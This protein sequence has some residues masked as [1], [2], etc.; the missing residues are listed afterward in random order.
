MN[1]AMKEV[2]ALCGLLEATAQ[3]D[4]FSGERVAEM[5]NQILSGHSAASVASKHWIEPDAAKTSEPTVRRVY[6]DKGPPLGRCS[7]HPYS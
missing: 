1:N 4:M 7:K 3:K 6:H 5:F 2:A